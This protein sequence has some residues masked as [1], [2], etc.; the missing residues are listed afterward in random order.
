MKIASDHLEQVLN[1][2]KQKAQN[3][4]GQEDLGFSKLLEQQKTAPAAGASA[5]PSAVDLLENSSMVGRIMAGQKI[6]EK[7]A[8]PGQQLENALD[9]MEEYAAAL[10]DTSRSLK[11]IEPLADNLQR[12][13]G[14]LSEL[15]QSLPEDDPLKGLSND[16]AILATVESMKFKRGDY[17]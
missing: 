5:G 14:Q 1:V 12:T 7:A 6:G 9:Q 11:D 4:S 17:V 16:A 15:S 2:A 13:A 3:P 8:T 10:G